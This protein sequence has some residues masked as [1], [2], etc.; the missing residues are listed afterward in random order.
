VTKSVSAQ[1]APGGAPQTIRIVAGTIQFGQEALAPCGG[2]TPSNTEKITLVGTTGFDHLIVDESGGW[3]VPGATLEADT[4]S[5]I[6]IAANLGEATDE[7]TVIGADRNDNIS[8]G[9]S[10]IALNADGDNDVTWSP[11]LNKVN[12]YGMGGRNTINGLGGAG[13]GSGYN[14]Q[15]F[16]YAGDAGDTLRGGTGADTLIGGAG[17]D[18]LD[19]RESG[20]TLDGRAGNDS[21]LGAGGADTLTGGSGSDTFTGADGADVFYAADGEADGTINGGPLSDTLYYDAGLDLDVVAVET[22]IAG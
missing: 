21:L 17:N 22:K 1:L 4:T 16:A 11:R 5:E 19:G 13:S 9:Q 15:L 18:L 14:G 8:I 2:A 20:D 10:G 12:V 3:F 7:L 6:E